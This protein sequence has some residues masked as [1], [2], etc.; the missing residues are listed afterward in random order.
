M[1]VPG[2]QGEES[3]KSMRKTAS[4]GVGARQMRNRPLPALL[5]IMRN[6]IG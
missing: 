4:S 1:T 5:G 6:K 2:T 3:P